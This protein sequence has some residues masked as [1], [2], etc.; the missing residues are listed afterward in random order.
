MEFPMIVS[1]RL[2]TPEEQLMIA[3][4][5]GRSEVDGFQQYSVDKGPNRSSCRERS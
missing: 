3:E 2:I 5:C 1:M 4:G